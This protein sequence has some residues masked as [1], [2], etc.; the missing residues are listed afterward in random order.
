[1]PV[2]GRSNVRFEPADNLVREEGG[3]EGGGDFINYRWREGV[4]R[5][6]KCF[7]SILDFLNLHL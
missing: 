7:K 2:L 6:Q 5:G 4:H 3:R 1:M